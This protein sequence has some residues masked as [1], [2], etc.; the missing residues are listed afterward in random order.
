[1]KKW[2]KSAPF[3]LICA[4]SLAAMNSRVL[5]E[6]VKSKLNQVDDYSVDVMIK[7]DVDFLKIKDS[8]GRL[9][10]KKPDKVKLESKRLLMMPKASLNFSPLFLLKND[11]LSVYLKS[12]TLDSI[13]TDVIKLIPR[14]D[15]SQIILATLWINRQDSVVSKIEAATKDKGS[16]SIS[17]FYGSA[18]KYGLA[19]SAKFFFNI[20]R[21]RFGHFPLSREA[22]DESLKKKT[23]KAV[24]GN[25]TIIYSDY[26][27]NSGLKDNIFEDAGEEDGD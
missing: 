1:M 5:L 24:A 26:K 23:G 22:A 16:F 7:I 9:F 4:V 15:N 8:R 3:I 18:I 13:K 17:F 10:F 20:S 11:F 27:I 21:T 12:D 14:D 25:A 6:N 2:I 19:D